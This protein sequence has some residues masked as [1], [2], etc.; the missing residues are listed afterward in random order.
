M[1]TSVVPQPA[2]RTVTPSQVEH[3]VVQLRERPRQNPAEQV[4]AVLRAL[5]LTVDADAERPEK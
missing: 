5:D 2:A 3:A 4:Q 1:T